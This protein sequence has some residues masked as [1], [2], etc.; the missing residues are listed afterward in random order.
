MKALIIDDEKS[1]RLSLSHFLRRRGYEVQESNSCGEALVMAKEWLP[2]LVFLD[3]LLPDG[4]G[5]SLLPHLVAPEIGACV[6]MMTGCVEL[7]KAVQAMRNGAEYYFPKPLDL[8]QVAL[9]LDRLE[10]QIT[11]KNKVGHH[12]RLCEVGGD[13]DVIIGESP[14]IIGMQRLIALLAKNS[15]TPVLIFGESGSGKE[16]AV[17]AIHRQS[18]AKGLLVEINCASLSEALLESEL[19]GHEKGAF[20]D[21]KQMKRGLF[22]LADNGTIFFD[23]LAEMPLAIQA[24]LLKVLDTKTFRRVGGVVDVKSNARFIGATNRDITTMVGNGLFREDL[25]YRIN[26]MPITVPP[27]RERGKDIALL[28]Y[29]FVRSLSENMGKGWMRISP[30]AM[31]C[32]Q[33]S[34]WPGNIRELKNIIERALIIADT[35]EILPEHLPAEIRTTGGLPIP[36]PP[37]V[38]TGGIRPLWQV[39]EEYIQQTLLATDNNH[40]RTALLLGISRST[41]LAKLKKKKSVLKSDMH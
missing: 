34:Y 10:E 19:F 27:L 15:A 35:R 29:F 23:E 7:D 36:S 4:D 37:V 26:V 6:I 14:Q 24:K 33:H 9:I 21:A 11:L 8:Q 18:G 28:A 41:L 39:E 25:Y 13:N 38:E 20:T 5:E 31:S 2:D 32:L 1:I 30:E 40:S 16:L 12:R 17:R 3:R 22:E